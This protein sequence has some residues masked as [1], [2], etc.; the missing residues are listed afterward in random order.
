M[1]SL[2]LIQKWITKQR[3]LTEHEY[4]KHWPR[5][6]LFSEYV[7]FVQIC[8]VFAGPVTNNDYRWYYICSTWFLDIISTCYSCNDTRH[9]QK[10]CPLKDHSDPVEAP[11]A[12]QSLKRD[13][14]TANLQRNA[15][16]Q[17]KD[18]VAQLWCELM[19]AEK[20]ESVTKAAVTTHVLHWEPRIQL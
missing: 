6:V 20:E 12:V 4:H 18:K 15:L 1:K 16:Q 2:C 8:P 7:Y 9:F 19:A 3:K 11:G 5:N 10:N 14:I 17:T 13:Q